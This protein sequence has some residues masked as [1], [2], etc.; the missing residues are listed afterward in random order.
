MEFLVLVL[1][2]FSLT[3]GVMN[4]PLMGWLRE[5]ASKF[6]IGADMM[7]CAHCTGFWCGVICV[8][9]WLVHPV[10]LYPL[11]LAGSCLLIHVVVDLI[12]VMA[13]AIEGSDNVS[14]K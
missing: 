8:G 7:K 4:S 13:N 14:A 5:A 3:F 1:A 2:T 11:A 12:Q 9:I 6:P 10:I